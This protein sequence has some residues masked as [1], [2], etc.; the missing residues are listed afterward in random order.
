MKKIGILKEKEEET[1]V[2]M[3]PQ[4]VKKLINE[5]KFEVYVE[6]NAGVKAGFS[7][8]MYL[9]EGAYIMKKRE[10]IA[11]LDILIFINYP[12]SPFTCSKN[13]KQIGIINPLFHYQKLNDLK[14]I[15]QL[16]SLDLMP[17]STKAQAMDVLSSMASLSGYKAVIKG[18]EKHISLL[19][20]ITTAAG[21]VK[22]AKILVLG[23]GVA[24]LQ[25]I[26]TAK[27]L[28]AIVNAFDVR[29]SAGEEVRSLGAN[30]IE[31]EGAMENDNAGGYAVEQSVD[32]LEK[33]RLLIDKYVSEA[34]IVIATA[35]IPGKRAPLLIEK[36]SIEKMKAGSVII[37]LASEQGGNCAYTKDEEEIVINGVKIIGN[38]FLSRELSFTASN[39]LSTNYFNFLKHMDLI[40]KNEL[41]ND[42]II[43]SCLIL[44]NGKIV[45]ERVLQFVDANLQIK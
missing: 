39:L 28:G 23:A 34:S 22:P 36:Q 42:P 29:K 45:H 27:R 14:N 16:Y 30:F 8:E 4:V 21:T 40:E 13:T 6:E 20:M 2:C 44:E 10:K 24:G 32:Y 38:S 26:A 25:A 31:V 37:D 11:E 15:Y 5:L 43:D 12:E 19:P 9:N 41:I 7:N 17:R 35:N 3:V 33:Q 1:R 18:A